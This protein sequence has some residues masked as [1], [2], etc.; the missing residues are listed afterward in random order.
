LSFLALL[1]DF[2][3]VWIFLFKGLFTIALCGDAGKNEVM[4]NCLFLYF[5]NVVNFKL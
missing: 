2:S 5:K 3:G 4:G 1:F